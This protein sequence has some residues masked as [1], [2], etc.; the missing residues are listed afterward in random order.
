MAIYPGDSKAPARTG[1]VRRNPRGVPA[2]SGNGS[3][4]CGVA[5]Q[6]ACCWAVCADVAALLMEARRDLHARNRCGNR[7]LLVALASV[8]DGDGEVVRVLLDAGA[9]NNYGTSARGLAS[10]VAS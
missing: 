10:K 1:A 7:S 8:R 2:A 9:E 3:V 6:P 4:P 5:E